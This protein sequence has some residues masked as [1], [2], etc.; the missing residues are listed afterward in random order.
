MLGQPQL[1]RTIWA[2]LLVTLARTPEDLPLT[3][4]SFH[5]EMDSITILLQALAAKALEALVGKAPEPQ[6]VDNGLVLDLTRAIVHVA[7]AVEVLGAPAVKVLIMR[8]EDKDLALNLLMAPAHMGAKVSLSQIV[9]VVVLSFDIFWACWDSFC[10]WFILISG[11][12]FIMVFSMLEF[13]D[14]VDLLLRGGMGLSCFGKAGYLVS[15]LSYF[16]HS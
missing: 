5:P 11:V 16:S 4:T 8:E 6:E 14:L 3:V 13:G 12:C 7:L 10:L 9:G 1:T 2:T 15:F